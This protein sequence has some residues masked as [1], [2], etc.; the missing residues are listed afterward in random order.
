MRTCTSKLPTHWVLREEVAAI[1][2]PMQIA[3]KKFTTPE[4][5]FTVEKAFAEAYLFQSQIILNEIQLFRRKTEV[6][7]RDH[8][9]RAGVYQ[10]EQ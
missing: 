1:I 3:K 2:G 5:I 6:A 9:P 4:P 8:D 7:G 10:P